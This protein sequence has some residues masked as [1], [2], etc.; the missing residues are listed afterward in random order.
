[1]TELTRELKTLVENKFRNVLLI[2]EISNFKRHIASGHCY[3]ILKDEN[4]QI[5]ATL[6]NF[7]FNALNFKP[8]DGQKVLI[9]GRI[10]LYEPRG[11]Y[12][13]DVLGMQ[14]YGIGELQLAF[15]K[16]KEKLFN[17][18]LFDDEHKRLLPEFPMRVGIVTSETG[19]VIEDFKNVAR[20]RFPIVKLF[21]FPANVQGEGSK[22][23]VVRSIQQ[24]N[25]PEYKLDVLVI[26]RGGGSIEDLWT[27][28]EEI[29]ARAVYN[30]KIPTVSA[31]GHEIDYTICD[32]VAD[33]RAPTPSAAAELIFPDKNDLL[34]RID[35]IDYNIKIYIKN[36][37][38]SLSDFL[39][40]F[41]NNYF[42]N[43]PLDILND[44]KMKTDENFKILE[45]VVK[46]QIS[47]YAQN[48]NY[49][50]K[51]FFNLSPEQTLKRGFT[52]VL[53]ENKIVSRKISLN[54]KDDVKIRFYDGD[55]E[56]EV[57]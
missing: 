27:F 49:M 18:G 34:E 21:L 46:E 44:Y 41:A 6:W 2:G 20:K 57:K 11:T 31:I 3:F 39:I 15:E 16:L 55:A 28:N 53:R 9:T 22:E 7:R 10:T 24:A 12:Q 17:E 35:K 37:V 14:K 42:F 29:I 8:E 54:S 13:I 26:A 45:K 40:T 5:N 36:K 50:D 23:S 48:L 4:S 33:L 47:S 38:K 25:K 32:F 52:Y 51:I 56:A 43:R 1:V 30:S 19:A